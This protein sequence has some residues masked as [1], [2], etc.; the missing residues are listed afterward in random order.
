MA[1]ELTLELQRWLDAHVSNGIHRAEVLMAADGL[2]ELRS[3]DRTEIEELIASWPPP[4]RHQ[5]VNA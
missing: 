5:F 3:A 4:A 2:E 1:Q